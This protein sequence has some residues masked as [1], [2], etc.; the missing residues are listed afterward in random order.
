ML[1]PSLIGFNFRNT[2]REKTDTQYYSLVKSTG[3]VVITMIR[4]IYTL[5]KKQALLTSYNS[6]EYESKIHLLVTQIQGT[7]VQVWHKLRTIGT[8]RLNSM[9]K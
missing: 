3:N 6:E 2:I 1:S 9:R 4:K 8:N 5:N 7:T